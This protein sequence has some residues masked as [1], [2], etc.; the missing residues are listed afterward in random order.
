MTGWTTAAIVGAGLDQALVHEV[1]RHVPGAR[2]VHVDLVRIDRRDQ[3][4]HPQ[5]RLVLALVKVIVRLHPQQG[6]RHLPEPQQGGRQR[7]E[8]GASVRRLL[9]LAVT[10]GENVAHADAE[11][12][13]G[14]DRHDDG[15]AR[16]G[17][18]HG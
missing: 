12:E 3:P 11:G 4:H 13:Q 16:A 7:L 14:N 9:V 5:D 15:I 10:D 17:L 8:R 6:R 2:G 18:H 1:V